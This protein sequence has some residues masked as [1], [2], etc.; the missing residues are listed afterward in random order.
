MSLL[1][2]RVSPFSRVLIYIFEFHTKSRSCF[3]LLSS[4][5]L[6]VQRFSILELQM[7][8]PMC[9][10]D[11]KKKT[12]YK[13]PCLRKIVQGLVYNLHRLL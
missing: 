12:K 3:D 1:L 10:Y 6:I 5:Y 2:E 4:A 9:S 13:F 7:N 8:H 11:I